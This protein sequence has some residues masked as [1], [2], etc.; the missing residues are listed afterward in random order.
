MTTLATDWALL[1]KLRSHFLEQKST[2]TE[3]YWH[4]E[5]ELSLYDASFARRISWKWDYVCEELKKRTWSWPAEPESLLFVDWGCGTGVATRQILEHFPGLRK[6]TFQVFDRSKMAE[7]FALKKIAEEY[8]GVDAKPFAG[9]SGFEGKKIVL[10]LSHV[11]GELSPQQL[12]ALLSL[13]AMSSAFIWVDSGSKECARKLSDLRNRL[14]RGEWSV[15]AP[16]THQGVCEMSKDEN[17]KHWCHSF[18]RPPRDVFHDEFWRTF[19]KEV[20]VDLRSLPL[21]FLVMQKPKIPAHAEGLSRVV[22]SVRSYKGYVKWLNCSSQGL[23]DVEMQK[24]LKAEEYKQF[25]NNDLDP[26]PVFR[27]SVENHRVVKIGS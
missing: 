23:G 22:G 16:C 9:G 18:A 11:I 21:S 20:G 3:N 7:A 5:Q 2:G 12:G 8:P 10:L 6:A 19:S 26:S 25:S 14:L 15:F 13:F 4:S 24:R 17:E 27:V 1:K